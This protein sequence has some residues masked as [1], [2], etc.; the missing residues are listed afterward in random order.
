MASW[1]EKRTRIGSRAPRV[2]GPVKVTGAAKYTSDVQPGG[3]LY[4]MILRSKW[5]KAKIAGISLEK[6]LQ[7][8][9]IKA[10]LLSREGERTVRYY[11]EELA[12]VA[13]T[14]KQACLDA[15]RAIEVRATPLPFVVREEDARQESAP[16]VWEENPNLSPPRVNEKGE[17]DKA[18]AECA[19]VVEGFYNTAVQV[20][21]PLEPHGHTISWTDAGVTAWSSTQGVFS[22]RDGLAS[23]LGVPQNQVRVITEHMGGGFGAKFGPGIEGGLAARLSKAAGAPVKIMLTRFDQALAAGNRPSSFQKIKL[24]AS[25]D[26]KL[27]AFEF[28]N[29]GTAG[30]GSGGS[31]AGGGSGVELHAPYIYRVPNI[32]VKQ[33]AVAV[34]AGSARAF[35]AP[36]SP[37]SSYGIEGIL[38]EL[39]LKLNLDPVELRIKND[40]SE[41]RQKQY[42]LGAERFGWSQKY[43]KP[44]TS[45]GVVKTGVGCGGATWG[46]GGNQRSRAEA[47]IN[48]DGSVEVRC[49]TQDL[50]TGT[51]TLVAL[52]AAET[53]GLAPDQIQVQI[54]DTRFPYGND[55]GGSTTA[56][57]VCP[58]VYDACTRALS[59]LQWQASVADARGPNWR[60]A[61]KRLGLQPLVRPGQWQ[62]GLSSS[63]VGGV[64][65]AEV[66]VDTETGFV[67]V[68]K[69]TCVQDCGLIVS[70]LTCESQVNGGIIMGI[71]YALYEERVMDRQTGVV[72]NPNFETYKLPALADIPEIDIVLMDMPER[73]VI[74][75]GEPVTI[76]TAAA[77]ANAVANALGVRV[78]SLPITPA[79][80]LAALGKTGGAA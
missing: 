55:S 13:G 73:G 70:K 80:V 40:P 50:G 8:P 39:A 65:F 46:G 41:V 12:A 1:P 23:N 34:N 22:V 62:R 75:I 21:H 60:D 48:P 17:V 32:R 28:E 68:K 14:S 38:D 72:L 26:G 79:R 49:G 11:G 64:Q 30:I 61:C 16:R 54:G 4:G 78:R 59:A 44:G 51:R 10:A 52:V 7:V 69:V 2:D 42:R 74:G 25:A 29:Y 77:I 71:G 9:G 45:P 36:A 47:Q 3:W 24:G 6:A 18:F 37:P 31:T 5:P 63:G 43:R 19:A 56:A 67:R 76:P 27:Q 20:H 57:S 66:E 33:A 53:F 58:A 35:R 15:L